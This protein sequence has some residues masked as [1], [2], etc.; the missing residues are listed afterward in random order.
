MR[1]N[2][3]IQA[4]ANRAMLVVASLAAIALSGCS[5]L[6]TDPMATTDAHG[7]GTPK[8]L[9]P[10]ASPMAAT[11]TYTWH[12]VASQWVNKGDAATVSGGRS[13]IQFVRGALSQ[14]ATIV[15][16]ERDPSIPDVV[17]GPSGTVLSKASTLTISYANSPVALS[18]DFLKMYHFNDST[19]AWEVLSG[20]N[21]LAAQTFTAKVSVLGRYAVSASDPTKAGW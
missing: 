21:D 19:G 13:K 3:T 1:R 2:H 17:I 20:T 11:S 4:R 9:S 10:P 12:Q 15:I 18:P 8:V 14:G 7:A 6:P 5:N 16:S